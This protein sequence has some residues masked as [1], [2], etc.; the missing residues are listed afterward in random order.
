MRTFRLGSSSLIHAPGILRWAQNGY[1][2]ARDRKNLLKGEIEWRQEGEA[3][4]FDA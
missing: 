4:V 3:V 2:F 1:R